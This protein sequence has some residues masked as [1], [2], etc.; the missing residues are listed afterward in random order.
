MF[1]ERD[2]NSLI[3]Q[4]ICPVQL[5]R[6]YRGFILL[7]TSNQEGSCFLKKKKKSIKF[8]QKGAALRQ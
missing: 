5:E 2:S 3:A 6:I 7:L 8:C 4:I 1:L